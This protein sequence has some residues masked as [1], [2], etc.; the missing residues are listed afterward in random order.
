MNADDFLPLEK[1]VLSGLRSCGVDRDSVSEA[2]PLG[3]AVSGGADSL[4]LLLSLAAIFPS[5]LLRVITVDHGIRSEK[6]SG[7]DAQFVRELCE[8]R[9]ISCRV[10][11]F[12]PGKI[13]RL[14][15]DRGESIEAL[16]RTM[17]Y[18]IFDAFIQNENLC[19]LALAHNQNDQCETLLMRFLQGSGIEGLGGIKRVRGKFIRP[20]LAISRTEIES[21]LR[22]KGQIWRTDSTNA[23]TAYVRNKIRTVLVPLLNEHFAGWQKALLSGAKKAAADEECIAAA[24]PRNGFLSLSGTTQFIDRAFF[25]NLHDALKRRVFFSALN[26]AGFGGRFP[27]RLYEEIASWNNEPHHEIQANGVHVRLDEQHLVIQYGVHHEQSAQNARESGFSV[28]I[29]KAGQSFTRE[30]WTV[31]SCERQ[32]EPIPQMNDV[33]SL[34]FEKRKSDDSPACSCVVTVKLPVLVRSAALTDSVLTSDLAHKSLN[35]VFEDWKVPKSVRQQIPVVEQ[36]SLGGEISAVIGSLFDFKNW[37]VEVSK[38][39]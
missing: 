28:L 29:H 38:L 15:K 10:A 5:S 24:V 39:L 2:S 19:A 12:E 17:R 16:A 8:N 3:V 21:Y 7:G 13:A 4:S 11:N 25:Y 37:I 34:V 1:K 23:D 36:V 35:A 27:F 18:E 22:D 20:L 33:C 31:R 30:T 26:D 9:G 14:A 32:A 6:E